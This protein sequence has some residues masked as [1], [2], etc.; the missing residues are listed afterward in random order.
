MASLI[1]SF[2]GVNTPDFLIIDK[3]H[4]P[5]LP[6]SELTSIDIPMKS[7]SQFVNK[8]HGNRTITIDLTIKAPGRD[9]V[10]SM[11]DQLADFLQHDE[12]QPIIFRD[13]PGRK[14]YAILDGDTDLEKIEHLGKGSIKLICHD[15]H[16]YGEQRSY[17]ITS[18]TTMLVNYGNRQTAPQISM[19]FTKNVT[20]FF[21]ATDKQSLYF[22]EPFDPTEKTVTDTKPVI[23][24]D[25]GSSTTDWLQATNF[26]VDGGRVLGTIGSNGYS[27]SQAGKDYGTL[28]GLWHGGSMV[29]SLTKQIQDFELECQVGFA[30]SNKNQK[31]RIEI[32]LLDINN[33]QLGKIAIRDIWNNLDNP[34]FEFWVGKVNGGGVS[35]TNTYGAYKGVFSNFNGI[36]EMGRVGKK[37]HC[38]IAKVDSNGR[39][40]TRHYKAFTDWQNKYMQKVAKIQLHIAAYDKDPAVDQM[41]ISNVY[42]REILSKQSN[43]VDYVFRT[44]DKL[45]IDCE[46]GEIYKNGKLFLERLYPGSEFLLL[47]KAANGLVV[48]DYSA[49]K[50]GKV[51]FTERW[52]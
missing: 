9:K 31:G 18:D 11:G 23:L 27:F 22:G 24:N 44:G 41:W 17:N 46:T 40:H 39:A 26:N 42:F 19:T 21:I 13:L 30:S 37:W 10:M 29:R 15:P 1:K 49:I 5:P 38:Y 33:N 34:Q 36:I 16:G 25:P 8:K 51:T 20:D 6:P 2:A 50:D 28:S 12:P 45:L 4:L 7:G 3:V 52:L 35:V 43:Q 14:Y 47:D 48:S 32:Y